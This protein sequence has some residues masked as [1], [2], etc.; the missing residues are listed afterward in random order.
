MTPSLP[1]DPSLRFLKEQ[2]K[3]LL[4]AHKAGDSAVCD[5]LRRLH[6]FAKGTDEAILAADIALKEVQFALAMSYGFKSWGELRKHVAA[7]ELSERITKACWETDAFHVGDEYVLDD[8]ATSLNRIALSLREIPDWAVRVRE[9]MP[10]YGFEL[11]SH[12]WLAGL[13]EAME[14]VGAQ[15]AW[16]TEI[17]RCGDV[18][19]S[20][21]QAARQ[22]ADAVEAWLAGR[23]DDDALRSRIRGTLGESTPHKAEAALCFV[24][25]VRDCFGQSSPLDEGVELSAKWRERAVGNPIVA[26]MFEGEGF[27]SLLENPCG[28]KTIDGLDIYIE[29]IGGDLSRAEERHAV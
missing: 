24:E 25:L 10:K 7:Q 9:A 16:P 22:R 14:M 19:E 18:P 5:V 27:D 11:C 28:Y 12:R 29:I 3:D 15:K 20:V 23:Q 4:K 13:R 26:T 1:P 21:T 6:R 8:D 2:A 17:G